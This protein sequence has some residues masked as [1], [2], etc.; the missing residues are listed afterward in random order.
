MLLE[1][2]EEEIEAGELPVE[3][4]ESE[5]SRCG[6][7]SKP[8]SVGSYSE[9]SEAGEREHGVLPVDMLTV[10]AYSCVSL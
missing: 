5:D 1:E 8:F 2:G 3:M 9:W 7:G 4:R 6:R 10:V